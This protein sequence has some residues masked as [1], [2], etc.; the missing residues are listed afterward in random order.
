[1]ATRS[2]ISIELSDKYIRQVYCHWDGYLEHVGKTLVQNYNTE[3]KINELLDLGDISSLYESI[4]HKHDFDE[5]VEGRSTFYGR[6]RGDSGTQ[7][8]LWSSLE[9]YERNGQFEEYN[10]IFKDGVWS[11][12]GNEFGDWIDVEYELKKRKVL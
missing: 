8:R 10:Y 7:A 5:R 12:V 4:G 3:E 11:C 1:M 9:D 6:D 2:T